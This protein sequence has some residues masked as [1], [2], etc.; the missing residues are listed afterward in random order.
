MSKFIFWNRKDVFKSPKNNFDKK[1]D[2]N[3]LTSQQSYRIKSKST[4]FR[5]PQE[6]LA[7]QLKLRKA[8]YRT[9]EGHM[10]FICA[11]QNPY[12]SQPCDYNDRKQH[13]KT[14][15]HKSAQNLDN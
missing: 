5:I 7:I 15:S 13:E 4:N 6:T 8:Q 10:G 2:T 11:V 9:I 3:K 12:P 1:I 14:E